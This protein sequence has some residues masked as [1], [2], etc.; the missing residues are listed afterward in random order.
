[1]SGPLSALLLL[2]ALVVGLEIAGASFLVL[3]LPWPI[4]VASQP[5]VAGWVVGLRAVGQS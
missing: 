3:Q 4:V 1:M 2:V 5:F